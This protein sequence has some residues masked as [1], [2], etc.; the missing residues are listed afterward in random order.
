MLKKYSTDI[1]QRIHRRFERLYGERANN[2]T[3]RL[4]MLVGRY[5]VDLHDRCA[6]ASWNQT[7]TVLITYGDMISADEMTPLAALQ[8]FLHERV[9]HAISTGRTKPP[10]IGAC[11]HVTGDLAS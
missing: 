4:V 11:G 10:P 2:C 1:M 3:D 8:R 9:K 7:D 5:N 6:F